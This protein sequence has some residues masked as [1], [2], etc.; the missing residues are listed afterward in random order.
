MKRRVA[1]LLLVVVMVVSCFTAC[2]ENSENPSAS[3]SPGTD[4]TEDAAA[5][6]AYVAKFGEETI[7]LSDFNY[8]LYDALSELDF[9][10]A[11]IPSDAT[12][13][14]SYR[15]M[16][17]FLRSEKEEGV[18]YFDSVVSRALELC[19]EFKMTKIKAKENGYYP[20]GEDLQKIQDDVDDMADYY[21]SYY[22]SSMGAE[23]RD[24]IMQMYI[25][26][27]V[28]EYK[29]FATEQQAI[30][31]YAEAYM[32]E[33][34][35][36][37]AELE[38]F[39][40]E[41]VDLFRVVTV[42][43]I[44]L[45]TSKLDDEGNSV[46]MTEDEKAAVRQEADDLL[47]MIQ[48]DIENIDHYTKGWSEDVDQYGVVNNNGLYD[49]TASSSYV[50]SFLNWAVA[51]EN[52]SDEMEIVESSY[53]YHIMKCEGITD[54]YTSTG[55]VA[56]SSSTSVDKV[57]EAVKTEFQNVAF[58]KMIQDALTASGVTVSDVKLEDMNKALEDYLLQYAGDEEEEEEE[59]EEDSQE[60]DSTAEPQG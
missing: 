42:R 6:T 37:D 52:V 31:K 24:E 23:T 35:T 39:Y 4:A 34:S 48:A 19:V 12:E 44:L 45:K 5:S 28:N 54:Y 13:A 2:N 27:N 26:M 46:T 47:Q 50:E 25:G 17:A 21:L 57:K 58:E 20:E 43:H 36:T 15:L 3:A 51:C 11:N 40:T 30:S 41:N 60:P 18:T 7:W 1:L 8:F 38:N 22:G 29:R 33:L 32:Q 56:D 53:G 16:V 49:V 9:S 59:D 10:A 55:T 14:E